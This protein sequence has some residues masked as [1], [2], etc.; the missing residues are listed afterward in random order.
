MQAV[1]ELHLPGCGIMVLDQRAGVV[2]Q[3]LARQ[4][5]EVAERTLDPLQPCRLPLVLERVGVNPPRVAQRRHEQAHLAPPEALHLDP[6]LA[7][8]DLQLPPRRRLE[9]N[10]RQRRRRKLLPQGKRE[11]TPTVDGTGRPVQATLAARASLQ[12]Q[13]RSSLSLLA[14]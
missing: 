1:V 6:A 9:P 10:R 3:Q 7:E 5:A 14:R 12:F 11:P 13:G 4:P 2:E 8:V